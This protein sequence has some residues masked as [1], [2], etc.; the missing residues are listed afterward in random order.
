[1]LPDGG[2]FD[3]T[4]STLLAASGRIKTLGT[5]VGELEGAL[6]S[7]GQSAQPSLDEIAAGFAWSE[8]IAAW[9]EG[10]SALQHA[11]ASYASNTMAAAVAY[12]DVDSMALPSAPKIPAPAPEFDWDKYCKPNL[13]GMMPKECYQA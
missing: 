4:P 7:Q 1:M 9:S 10:I 5:D 12:E 2:G 6:R 8:V 13:F 11:L 3:V